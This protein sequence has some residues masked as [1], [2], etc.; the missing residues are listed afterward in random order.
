MQFRQLIQEHAQATTDRWCRAVLDTYPEQAAILFGKRKNQFANPVGHSMREGT[1]AIVDA[2]ISGTQLDEARRGLTEI[3]RIRAVQ[4]FS[5]SQAVGFV[6]LL[7]DAMRSELGAVL[8]DSKHAAAWMELESQIDQLALAAFDVFVECR[9]Q[10]FEL[11]MNELKRQMPWTA[12]RA[13]DCS[14]APDSRFVELHCE[15]PEA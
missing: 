3:I 15:G 1:R 11:R 8:G 14:P 6:F 9:E 12:G 13:R 2:L 7:K 5:P 4:Q 10:V